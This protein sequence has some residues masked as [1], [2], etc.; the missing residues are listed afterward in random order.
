MTPPEA[1]VQGLKCAEPGCSGT[2]HIRT[3]RFGWFYSCEHWPA[4]IGT[5][6]ANKDGSPRGEP[7]TKELQGWRNKAHGTFDV[8][9]KNG[10]LTRSQAYAWL[11]RQLGWDYAPHM[12]D[13]TIEQCQEVIWVVN[14]VPHVNNEP[15]DGQVDNGTN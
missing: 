15:P 7:R 4:C 3:S 6:P 12:A 9:W 1:A 14:H 11:K 5:L 10:D 2:L 8:I 13:M